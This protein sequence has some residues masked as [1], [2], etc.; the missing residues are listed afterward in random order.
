MY[1]RAHRY[2]YLCVGVYVCFVYMY[3]YRWAWSSLASVTICSSFSHDCVYDY[4]LRI[5][6][7]RSLPRSGPK[8]E[9]SFI[10]PS[11]RTH[12]HLTPP[13][14]LRSSC[15]Q[16]CTCAVESK[17]CLPIQTWE[18]WT[19]LDGSSSLFKSRWA[20][21]RAQLASQLVLSREKREARYKRSS[22]LLHLNWPAFSLSIVQER[23]IYP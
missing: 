11:V 19:A 5:T 12:N 16:Y 14:P 8:R 2:L 3:V 23:V 10:H 13:T 17:K 9:N 4:V 21:S 7:C 18:D 22:A 1:T 15:I 6:I 20:F